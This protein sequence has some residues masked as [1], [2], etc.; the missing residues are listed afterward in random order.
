MQQGRLAAV[1]GRI[2]PEPALGR[3]IGLHDDVGDQEVI[4]EHAAHEIE[5]QHITDRGAGTVTGDDIIG[6]NRVRP[7]RRVD[8]NADIIALV[9]DLQHLVA[10]A[11]FNRR[12]AVLQFADAVDHVFFE[13]VLL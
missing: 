1:K 4:F 3:E 2:K 8:Q 13:I 10:A 12:A 9:L 7:V 11:N 5:P 6:L